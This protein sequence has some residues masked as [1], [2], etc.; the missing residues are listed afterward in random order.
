ML[1]EYLKPG[2]EGGEM[3]AIVDAL[4]KAGGRARQDEFYGGG[5][6]KQFREALTR[7]QFGRAVRTSLP[8]LAEASSKLVMEKIVPRQK[9]GVFADLARLELAK[10]PDNAT[11][12]QA[13]AAMAHAWDSVDN[14]MGHSFTTTCSGTARRKTS[15]WHRSICRMECGNRSRVRGRYW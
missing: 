7:S 2:T 13:R 8:A 4:V 10:L 1:R 6:V 9:L 5:A 11:K 12:V 15:R 14:R 3:A